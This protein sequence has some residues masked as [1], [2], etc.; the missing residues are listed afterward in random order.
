MGRQRAQ[1]RDKFLTNPSE[2]LYDDAKLAVRRENAIISEEIPGVSVALYPNNGI[3][4]LCSDS[5]HELYKEWGT[6]EFPQ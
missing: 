1:R 2:R 5:V 4:N 6:L 3:G